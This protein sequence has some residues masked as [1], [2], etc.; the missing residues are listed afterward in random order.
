M[1]ESGEEDGFSSRTIGEP[2][3]YGPRED[4]IAIPVDGNPLLVTLA[5]YPELGQIS[6]EQYNKEGKPTG[7]PLKSGTAVQ[8]PNPNI[9]GEKIHFIVP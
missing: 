3:T 4:D 7:K 8:I 9:A 5:F 2:K 1:M 6:I